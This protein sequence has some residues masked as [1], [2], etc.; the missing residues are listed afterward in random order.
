MILNITNLPI[1]QNEDL[2]K[3]GKEFSRNRIASTDLILSQTWKTQSGALNFAKKYKEM[4]ERNGS[5]LFKISYSA[6]EVLIANEKRFILRT[7]RFKV[8]DSIVSV[9]PHGIWSA[10]LVNENGKNV[11]YNSSTSFK[12]KQDAIDFALSYSLADYREKMEHKKAEKER[13]II[14][15][16]EKENEALNNTQDERDLL[17]GMTISEHVDARISKSRKSAS[18]AVK[19]ALRNASF[20]AEDEAVAA[21]SKNNVALISGR[22]KSLFPDLFNAVNAA[23][24]NTI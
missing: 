6:V 8:G 21:L 18:E 11:G 17:D 9:S 12:E 24:N 4:C 7:E 2:L 20:D 19:K 22:V 10:S 3:K 23:I 15:A 1:L 5:S 13:S 16:R 14:V